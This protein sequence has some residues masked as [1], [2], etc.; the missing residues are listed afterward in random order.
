M[1]ANTFGNDAFTRKPSP[2]ADNQEV[3]LGAFTVRWLDLPHTPH[4]W[5]N[6]VLFETSSRT[7]FCSDLFTQVGAE[8]PPI[9]E[10]TAVRSV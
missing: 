7:L 4:G 2:L 8:P 6:G 5:G 10:A 1:E 9:V 3:S